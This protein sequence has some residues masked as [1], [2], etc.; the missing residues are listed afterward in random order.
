MNSFNHYSFGSVGQWLYEYV[1]GLGLDAH[2]PGYRRIVIHPRPGGGLTH[3]RAAYDSM[4]GTISSAWRANDGSFELDVEIPVN[5]TAAVH[6]PVSRGD[7]VTESGRPAV[8][9]PGVSFVRRGRRLARLRRRI[10]FVH[11]QSGRNPL[12]DDS[13]TKST[14]DGKQGVHI[15]RDLRELR[16]L[17]VGIF[18]RK[19]SRFRDCVARQWR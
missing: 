9:A 14:K 15:L 16:G 18:L 19:S 11:L 1:A 6:V 13:T 7:E 10:G 3:A 17:K 12:S 2:Q 4:H 5:T 8:S